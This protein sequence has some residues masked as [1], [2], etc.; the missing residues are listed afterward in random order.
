[1]QK[2]GGVWVIER[3]SAEHYKPALRGFAVVWQRRRAEEAELNKKIQTALA[4]AKNIKE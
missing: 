3:N 1:M 2:I 4:E